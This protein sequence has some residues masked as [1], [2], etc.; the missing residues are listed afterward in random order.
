MHITPQVR[1]LSIEQTTGGI[2]AGVA[3]DAVCGGTVVVV[4][5][6]VVDVVELL[7]AAAVAVVV[8]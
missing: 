7:V 4:V 2:T 6:V 3:I 1:A 5:E 8:V